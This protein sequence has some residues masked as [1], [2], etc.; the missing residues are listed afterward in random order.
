MAS[1]VQF[2]V[3]PLFL[4]FLVFMTLKLLGKITWSWFWV[5]APLWIGAVAGI[6][7]FLAV[8]IALAVV[9]VFSKK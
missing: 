8:V 3:S 2:G 6:S 7:F 9:A 1:K 4:L 5:S